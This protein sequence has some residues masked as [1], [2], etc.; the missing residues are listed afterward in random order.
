VDLYPDQ[1]LQATDARPYQGALGMDNPVSRPKQS[2]VLDQ[3]AEGQSFTQDFPG[4]VYQVSGPSV[5]GRK[6]VEF[7]QPVCNV[8]ILMPLMDKWLA[9]A[10]KRTGIPNYNP[11]LGQGVGAAGTATGLTILLNQ[12]AR[13][14]K[15]AIRGVDRGITRPNVEALF[16]DNMLHV[17]DPSIKG[18]VQIVASGAMGLFVKEQQQLRL[19]EILSLTNNDTDLS[20]TGIKGRAALL[21][22]GVDGVGVPVE[23]VIPSDDELDARQQAA[24]EQA[25]MMAGAA[26]GG[27]P[28]GA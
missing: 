20:I 10:E 21:R 23:D 8:A 1:V 2:P 18:D 13:P 26:G 12:A 6:P 27:P 3:M 4:K 9:M 5:Q 17:D 22:K 25:A 24:A 11:P 28:A 7:P 15:R 19:H 16:T 14:L